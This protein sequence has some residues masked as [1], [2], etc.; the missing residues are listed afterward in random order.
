MPSQWY[1]VSGTFQEDLRTK[2]YAV[3]PGVL[4][5]EEVDVARESFRG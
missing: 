4:M 3:V 1:N 5:P 2:G